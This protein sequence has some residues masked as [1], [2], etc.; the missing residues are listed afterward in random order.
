LEGVQENEDEESISSSKMSGSINN[1][2]S[3]SRPLPQAVVT[4]SL[5]RSLLEQNNQFDAAADEFLIHKMVEA[6]GGYGAILDESS[7]VS[8]MIWRPTGHIIGFWDNTSICIIP[9][10]Q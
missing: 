10:Q 5:V 3:G 8:K 2:N 1:N 6:A 9:I 7:F 4:D